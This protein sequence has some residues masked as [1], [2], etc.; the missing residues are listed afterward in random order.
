MAGALRRCRRQRR[1]QRTTSRADVADR[2]RNGH[3]IRQTPQTSPIPLPTTASATLHR[4]TLWGSI[5]PGS[6]RRCGAFH[7]TNLPKFS[8]Y[9]SPR[10]AVTDPNRAFL[11]ESLSSP[12]SSRTTPPT[13]NQNSNHRIRRVRKSVSDGTIA[14]GAHLPVPCVA[15]STGQAGSVVS[16]IIGSLEQ[17]PMT[18]QAGSQSG[19]ACSAWPD[20][21]RYPSWHSHSSDGS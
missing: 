1:R 2:R 8:R 15:S 20:E 3:W 6:G 12:F 11:P 14:S 21:Y 16:T 17:S 13:C 7:L 19:S 5:R 4:M 10:W 18:T 9:S